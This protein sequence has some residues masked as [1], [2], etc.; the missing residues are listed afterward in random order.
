MNKPIPLGVEHKKKKV[1]VKI[2]KDV[3]SALP[4]A[5]IM[6]GYNMRGKSR[7]IADAVRSMLNS[8]GWES[9]LVSELELKPDGQDVFTMPK[10][11]MTQI[12][13]EICRINIEH[14][15]L[16]PTQSAIIRAAINRR[17]IGFYKKVD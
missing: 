5:I 1:T 9:V 10:T 3:K 12:T 13:S 16:N 15:S 17:L 2:F 14:P 8:K 4:K 7:G 6:D 11:L